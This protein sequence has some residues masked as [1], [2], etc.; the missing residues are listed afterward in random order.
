MDDGWY[1]QQR[2]NTVG[3]ITFDALAMQLH[4]VSDPGSVKVWHPQLQHWQAAQ[5]VPQIVDCVFLRP[6]TANG[7]QGEQP[8]P[9]SSGNPPQPPP[10]T[11]TEVQRPWLI[12]VMLSTLGAIVIFLA[13]LALATNN[14]GRLSDSFTTIE[15]DTAVKNAA[16]DLETALKTTA[17]NI[18]LRL[19]DM[20]FET[21]TET[22][23]AVEQLHNEIEPPGL[24]KELDYAS[25]S[26]SEIEAYKGDLESAETKAIEALPRYIALLKEERGRLEKSAKELGADDEIIRNFLQVID[27]RH[28]HFTNFNSQMMQARAQLYRSYGD[29]LDILIAEFGKYTV[30]PNGQLIFLTR[31]VAESYNAATSKAMAAAERV[32]ELDERRKQLRQT[33]LEV[34]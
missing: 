14:I 24:A 7:I 16:G 10:Q 29:I 8:S 25:A 32:A 2:G 9:A 21:G 19:L 30:Q 26:R 18:L 5:H 22:T 4:V 17:S 3:P 20:A 27:R 6:A 28:A 23:R 34:P 11:D 13:I 12:V 1:C 31:G 33:Q 15:G